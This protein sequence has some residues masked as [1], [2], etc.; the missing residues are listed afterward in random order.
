MPVRRRV[1][2]SIKFAGTHLH[3]WVKRGTVRVKCLAYE[4]NAVSPVRSR[5]WTVRSGVERTN[6]EATVP[7]PQG[8]GLRKNL[9]KP[10]GSYDHKILGTQHVHVS[11]CQKVSLSSHPKSKI[12]T[13]GTQALLECTSP[14][15][16]G[17]W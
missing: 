10:K 17:K 16:G 8:G 9:K 1:T 12:V 14:E 6:H 7:P 5:T 11:L 4:H 13:C 2:P 3:T 15:S